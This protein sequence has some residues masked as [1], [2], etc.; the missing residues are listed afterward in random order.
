M[1][2]FF[3]SCCFGLAQLKK[4]GKKYNFW[5]TVRMNSGVL[6][7]ARGGSGAK[8]PP[9]AAR[10]NVSRPWRELRRRYK[11][12]LRPTKHESPHLHYRGAAHAKVPGMGT[13][14]MPV[15][16][17][18]NAKWWKKYA[19]IRS[20]PNQNKSRI[21]MFLH[22]PRAHEQGQIC[23]CGFMSKICLWEKFLRF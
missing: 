4:C 6:L 16:L 17:I 14:R 3:L 21:R 10:L 11:S 9:L 18:Q 22:I 23:I 12:E 1:P 2:T 7:V 8:A 19:Q 5:G 20:S 15:T 13:V